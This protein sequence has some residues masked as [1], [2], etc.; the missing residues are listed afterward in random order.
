MMCVRECKMNLFHYG[1]AKTN[2]KALS[3]SLGFTSKQLPPVF[4][5][6]YNVIGDTLLANWKIGGDES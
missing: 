2:D 1:C 4:V 6:F 3:E 5:M